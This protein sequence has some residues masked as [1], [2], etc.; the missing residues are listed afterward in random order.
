MKLIPKSNEIYVFL[1]EASPE[2]TLRSN[3]V[4]FRALGWPWVNPLNIYRKPF[5]ESFPKEP[6]TSTNDLGH[7]TNLRMGVNSVIVWHLQINIIGGH[8]DVGF[9]QNH[10]L[11]LPYL[12]H[13]SF[14]EEHP[15]PANGPFAFTFRSPFADH[16]TWVKHSFLVDLGIN[17]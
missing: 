16:R 11:H 15:N 6:Q 12:A 13:N 10:A 4:L 14:H 7:S 3:H 9:V 5:Q 17:D 2:S 8:L 1:G